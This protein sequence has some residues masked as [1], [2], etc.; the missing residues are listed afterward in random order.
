MAPD[1]VK[2]Y[3]LLTLISKH[4]FHTNEQ[5]YKWMETVVSKKLNVTATHENPFQHESQY[6]PRLCLFKMDF[7]GFQMSLQPQNVNA[8]TP[9]VTLSDTIEL[10]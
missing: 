10:A 1:L 5:I 2:E 9:V 4:V 8:N 7:S 3:S 6:R